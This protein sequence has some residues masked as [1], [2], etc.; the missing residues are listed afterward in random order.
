MTDLRH[1]MAPQGKSGERYVWCRQCSRGRWHCVGH[2]DWLDEGF[3]PEQEVDDPCPEVAPGT[4]IVAVEPL[5]YDVA[6]RAANRKSKDQCAAI[7]ERYGIVL[8]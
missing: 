5:F 6:Y 7:E 8:A 1:E 4:R 2:L 3:G